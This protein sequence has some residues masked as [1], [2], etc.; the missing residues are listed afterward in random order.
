MRKR[1]LGVEVTWKGEGLE[2]GKVGGAVL[3]GTVV[4]GKL[5]I[6]SGG[7]GKESRRFCAGW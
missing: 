5:K 7:F 1:P 3:G 2:V 4:E 6:C